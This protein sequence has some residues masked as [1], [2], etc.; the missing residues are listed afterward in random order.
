MIQAQTD[1]IHTFSYSMM[2]AYTTHVMA[3]AQKRQK[4]RKAALGGATHKKY[5][6]K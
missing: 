5:L 1:K 3:E 2:N 6:I 4:K